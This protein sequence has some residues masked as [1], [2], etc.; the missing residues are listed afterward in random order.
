MIFCLETQAEELGINFTLGVS[1]LD[2]ANESGAGS[3]DLKMRKELRV[4]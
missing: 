2:S 4:Y 1:L 3:I